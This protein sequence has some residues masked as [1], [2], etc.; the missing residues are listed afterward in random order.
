MYRNVQRWT[1]IF[2]YD[3]YII[4]H[5][6][7]YCQNYVHPL[8]SHI[9]SHGHSLSCSTVSKHWHCLTK[10]YLNFH[11]LLQCLHQA[12]FHCPIR[13][14]Q[15]CHSKKLARFIISI[16]QNLCSYEKQEV[17]ISIWPLATSRT[18][19]AR[20]GFWVLNFWW[21]SAPQHRK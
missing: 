12:H 2:V 19:C 9:R 8:Y 1:M 17:M 14:L 10:F 20:F 21:W 6:H 5:L 3:P 18:V 7:Y 11:L 16:T 15:Q 13:L 4:Y